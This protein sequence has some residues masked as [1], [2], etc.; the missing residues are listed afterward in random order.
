MNVDFNCRKLAENL[1]ETWRNLREII[2]NFKAGNR[3]AEG[4]FF[5]GG[6]SGEHA[7]KI[8]SYLLKI[9]KFLVDNYIE[10]STIPNR[11]FLSTLHL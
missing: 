11:K 4:L 2:E 8:E 7:E 5:G 1:R 6:G 3:D 10:N 9:F